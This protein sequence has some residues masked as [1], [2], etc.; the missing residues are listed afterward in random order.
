MSTRPSDNTPGWVWFYYKQNYYLQQGP[1]CCISQHVSIFSDSQSFIV[2]DITDLVSQ[3]HFPG[4]I[5]YTLENHQKNKDLRLTIFL[6]LWR[7]AH[8][9]LV[10]LIK[11]WIQE[12]DLGY[13]I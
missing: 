11:P 8:E 9:E 10:D 5:K 6:I 7:D 3:K 13:K 4:P 1:G 2:I 12:R